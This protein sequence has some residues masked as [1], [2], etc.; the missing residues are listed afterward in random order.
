[1][2]GL[3][4]LIFGFFFR[5]DKHQYLEVNF[6]TKVKIIRLTTKGLG[7]SFVTSISLF[8]SDDGV[9]FK[10]LKQDSK[11]KVQPTRF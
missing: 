9:I 10:P 8:Y 3:S 11:T 5:K 7:E 4:L 6:N 1:M 2:Y